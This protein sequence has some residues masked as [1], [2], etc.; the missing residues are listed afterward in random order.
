MVSG[1]QSGATSHAHAKAARFHT[2][3]PQDIR[4]ASLGHRYG[5]HIEV[6]PAR[7][8]HLAGALELPANGA[9]IDYGCADV[10]YRDFFGPDVNYVAADITGNP[11]ATLDLRQDGTIP[12]DDGSFDALMSTQVLEHVL[13][14]QTYIA[15]AY[16]VLRP[17][18]RMLLSTHGVF[19]YHPDPVDYWRWTG[20]GLRSIVERAGFEVVEFEGIVG[21][22]PTGLQMVQDGIYWHLPRWT[23]PL[24]AA[25]MQTLM[26]LTD[27]FHGAHSRAQN[28][29]VFALV[30]RKP[31]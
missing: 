15:E 17:G 31:S 29:Q 3:R 6:L 21:L 7:L 30:A 23:R 14:P 27:R 16:R 20:A 13:D 4:K 26:R 11:D 25:V 9:L 1:D 19:I 2:N 8:R 12:V 10:P 24:F 28:A 18:G 5:Y 22:V